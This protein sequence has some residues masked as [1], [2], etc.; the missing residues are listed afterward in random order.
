MSTIRPKILSHA[1]SNYGLAILVGE[2]ILWPCY[3]YKVT[4]PKNQ[5]RALNIF[6][7]TILRL[8]AAMTGDTQALAEVT[9]M[10][11]ELVAFIQRRLLHLGLLD[12]RFEHTVKG[13]ELLDSWE[14][15]P[16]LY[17]AYSSAT[18]YVD[19]LSG[20]LLPYVQTESEQ[21]QEISEFHAD[22]SLVGFVAG[23]QGKG[24]PVK[25]HLISGVLH[26]QVAPSSHS[27]AKAVTEY[28]K[29]L[30]QYALLKKDRSERPELISSSQAISVQD[31]AHLVHIHSRVLMQKGRSD[32]IV[33]DG[34]GLGFSAVFADYLGKKHP[35][36]LQDLKSKALTH[37]QG[38]SS[39]S[40]LQ[41]VEQIYNRQYPEVYKG[42]RVAVA[43]I[44]GNAGQRVKT[45]NAEQDLDSEIENAIKGLYDALEWALRYLLIQYPA[46]HWQ[47]LWIHQDNDA[48]T[49]LLQR[50]AEK[51]GFEVDR[52][53]KRIL[54]VQGG[55]IRVIKDGSVELH[56]LLALSIASASENLSHPLKA[57]A[58]S[59]PRSLH[60]I[61]R[62]KK[63][64]D[65]IQHGNPQRARLSV[66]QL[67]EFQR[68]TISMIDILLPRL[69]KV[70][71]TVHHVQSK[72]IDQAE[73]KAGIALDSALGGAY[74]FQLKKG[75]KD[76]LLS[77][78]RL[79]L[80]HQR[81]GFPSEVRL[82]LIN[83]YANILQQLFHEVATDQPSLDEQSKSRSHEWI[84]VL[85]ER[86]VIAD[87]EQIPKSLST[88]NKAKV[89]QAV[90]GQDC[91]LGANF[92]ALLYSATTAGTEQWITGLP[93]MLSCIDQILVL[94]GH[95]NQV[96]AGLIELA[97]QAL[98]DLKEQVF[99]IIIMLKEV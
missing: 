75:A 66:A 39:H 62:L 27:V 80:K 59:H 5:Q 20:H 10:D 52:Q 9:C 85:I 17:E 22:S 46:E 42:L 7:Q 73:I 67:Q 40:N 86:D 24:K 45:S 69:E 38:Y 37:D 35:K 3:A 77:V 31:D 76:E 57:L 83:L 61:V 34:F 16:E 21:Y 48:S 99:S 41:A 64:R 12:G 28:G 90:D 95:G 96:S 23:S 18:V 4:I 32:F 88:V 81:T 13:K 91:T 15:A 93:A 54:K 14:E 51:V 43:V 72:D 68:Q 33:S 82:R 44:K 11:K 94:R 29:R 70:E 74:V 92:I 36:W 71:A 78:E 58:R 60:D 89:R 97:D 53:S 1:Q 49:R 79:I 65:E 47:N 87:A 8:T 63:S 6:E 30:K 19:A 55:K 26:P 84:G 50:M 25:A 2:D 56:P 98:I